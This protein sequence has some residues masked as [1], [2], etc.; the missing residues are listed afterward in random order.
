MW[1]FITSK[2]DQ[3][4]QG[5]LTKQTTSSKIDQ[6]K[7]EATNNIMKKGGGRE[8]LHINQRLNRVCNMN[9]Y[10]AIN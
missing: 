9:N 1:K 5:Q 4:L 7:S 10:L 2:I 6:K 8:Y 3:Q